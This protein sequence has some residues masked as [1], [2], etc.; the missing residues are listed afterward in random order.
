MTKYIS[1]INSKGGVGKTTLCVNIASYAAIN[2]SL[3][4]N[5]NK[6][7]NINKYKN[8]SV[9]I[10]DADSQGSVRD[11]H[12]A[13]WEDSKIDVVGAD[14]ARSLKSI[15]S[16]V[17]DKYDYVFIDTPGKVGDLMSAAIAVADICLLPVQPSP[18]DIWASED[19][20][21]LIKT[22]QE[23][24]NN[25]PGAYYVL[26]RCIPNSKISAEVLTHIRTLEIPVF[27]STI[28][29]RVVYAV[30]AKNGSSVFAHVNVE[31]KK[32][33]TKLFNELEDI[34]EGGDL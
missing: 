3:N 2:K 31:A 19:T 10:V 34:L 21:E 23:L 28:A 4:N 22:R 20:A 33:I 16:V 11:W 15:K 13:N 12:N 29:Q 26:N 24:C 14:T 25:L 7:S 1:L 32:E 8:A 18:Y 9:L 5:L 6:V 30:S 27:S 17:G